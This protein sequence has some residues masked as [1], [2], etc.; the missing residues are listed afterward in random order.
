MAHLFNRNILLGISGGIAAYK[1]AELVRQLRE[2]GATVRVIMTR[3][4]REFITPLTLQALSGNPVHTEL[5]DTEAELG[6]SHIELARWADL[7]LI[8]PATAD[9]L[10]RLASGRADDLLTTVALATAAPLLLAPAM[11]QQMWR[12]PATAANMDTLRSRGCQVVGPASGEQACGDVG[13]GRMEDPQAIAAAAAGLFENGLLAGKR[14]VITAGPTREALDPV[15]Y[16]SNHSSGKMGYALAQAAIDAGAQTTLVSGPV[17][18]AAP[19]HARLLPVESASQMLD[20]CLQLL[21]ECDIFIACAAVA[22]YR[23]A[24]VEQQKIKKGP[25]QI[26][27]QLVRNPDIVATVA[28]SEPRPFT[29]G[30]AAE[31]TALLAHAQDKMLRKGLDMIVANDVSDRSIGFNSDNN[32]ATVLWPGGEQALPLTGKGA[33]A[34]MI[35]ELIAKRLDSQ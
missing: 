10:A 29:V 7:L 31:T 14:V 3:G 27:L 35:V 17:N 16:I 28:A 23:P 26:T 30:F 8:A 32:E 1:S 24:S 20:Q 2:R 19:S 15:R 6:M 5:L 4:A 9:L 22:D 25:E 11:N 18:L 33:M 21:P 34:R 12:D 13:P